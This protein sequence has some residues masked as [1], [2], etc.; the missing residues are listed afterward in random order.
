ML[1]EENAPIAWRKS[2]Y[3]ANQ[4]QEAC[5][6]VALFP[7]AACVRDSK[8]PDGAVLRFSFP[9]WQVAVAYFGRGPSAGGVHEQL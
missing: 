7:A 1:A 3:S 9:A 2:S 5:C 8:V 6:E 4:N